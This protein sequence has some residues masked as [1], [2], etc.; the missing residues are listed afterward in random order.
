MFL[1]ALNAN[2][3]LN[4]HKQAGQRTQS[5]ND[6]PDPLIADKMVITLSVH[7][8]FNPFQSCGGA[9]T[10]TCVSFSLSD[11]WM[12]ICSGA[13]RKW[14]LCLVV[15]ASTASGTRCLGFESQHCHFLATWSHFLTTL[16]LGFLICRTGTI[17]TLT[18]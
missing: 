8:S 6:R 5:L 1:R 13:D 4:S 2:F 14:Q 7:L 15:R 9:L 16:C 12:V 3:K 18:S 17:A 10:L 11:C